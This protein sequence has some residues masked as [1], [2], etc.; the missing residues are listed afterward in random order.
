MIY[1]IAFLQLTLI[2]AGVRAFLDQR[3][4]SAA[5]LDMIRVSR[6]AVASATFK[7][8]RERTNE[9]ATVVTKAADQQR[10]LVTKNAEELDEQLTEAFSGLSDRLSNFH[11]HVTGVH[12]AAAED[13][14]RVN[15]SI[16][17]LTKLFRPEDFP[18][19]PRQCPK[20]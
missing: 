14:A 17:A 20:Q 18:N 6:Q 4:Q 1:V 16:Q 5:I 3:K 9:I 19:V 7:E 10:A 13:R 2:A 8:L 11:D 15:D 12:H